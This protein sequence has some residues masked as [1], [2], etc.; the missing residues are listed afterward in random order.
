MSELT[1]REAKTI[2]RLLQVNWDEN[3]KPVFS[4]N[5]KDLLECDAIVLDELSMVDVSLFEAL[6]RAMPLGCRLIMVGGLRSAAKRRAGK[7]TGGFDC[8]RQDTGCAAE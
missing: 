3:D 6:L 5:E 1:G 2:H 8:Q 7:C 4:K